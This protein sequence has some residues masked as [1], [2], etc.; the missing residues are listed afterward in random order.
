[1]ESLAFSL[2]DTLPAEHVKLFRLRGAL[3][4]EEM[5]DE[6]AYHV[7]EEKG[8]GLRP[9]PASV[10]SER[11]QQGYAAAV[12]KDNHI[13]SY[14]SLVPI[15]GQ[16]NRSKFSAALA[17]VDRARMPDVEIYK[18]ATVWTHPAWRRRGIHVQLTPALM[19]HC[20]ASNNCLY[21]SVAVGLAGSPMMVKLGWRI[22][23]WSEIAF[24]SSLI[25]MPIKG[26]EDRV[27]R[28]WWPPAG[29]RPYDGG[30]ITPDQDTTH[31]WNRFCHL[32]VSSAPL[33][34]EANRQF[35]AMMKGDLR[36][37]REACIAVFTGRRESPLNFF[38]EQAI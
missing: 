35:S 2:A 9:I 1:M 14:T 38:Q 7:T 27:E 19:N 4:S 23:G 22:V 17:G 12:I 3:I 29:M 18:L 24:T 20:N 25:G 36:R 10:V 15:Y 26:L 21:T 8:T 16:A 34:I 28:R 6:L 37:W 13:I 11:W 33:A 32:W 31:D 5:W 30:H